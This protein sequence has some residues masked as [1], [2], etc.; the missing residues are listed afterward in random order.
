MDIYAIISVLLL[1]RH[2]YRLLRFRQSAFWMCDDD[3]TFHS[4]LALFYMPQ[5]IT[6]TEHS[7]L[8][9][10]Q[11]IDAVGLVRPRN[12][13]LV[14]F[15]ADVSVSLAEAG[16]WLAII[17]FDGYRIVRRK[18]MVAELG[19]SIRTIRNEPPSQHTEMT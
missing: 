6:Y 11:G 19:M 1:V 2:G 18:T 3:K 10:S 5:R 4:L 12:T 14:S 8:Y 7:K 13:N 9:S 17:A 16:F 15:V